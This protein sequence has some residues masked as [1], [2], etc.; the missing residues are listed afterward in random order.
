MRA[1]K[2][3]IAA[4]A[5]AS[6]PATGAPTAAASLAQNTQAPGFY[7]VALGDFTVTVLTDGST[8]VPFADLLHG[9]SPERVSSIFARA[10]GTPTRETSINAFL[11]DTGDRQVLID[12]GASSLF[13][14]C[15]GRLPATLSAAGYRAADID[16]ILLTHVH[17]DH[18]AGLVRD[19][20]R[21]FPNA[22][23]YLAEAELKF[24]A[25]DAARESAK[26]SHKRMFA[27]GQA[28]LAP[29]LEADR[30]RTFAGRTQLF[31][32]IASIPAPGHTPGHSFYRIESRGRSLLV[33]GDVIHSAEVQFE[34]P[35]VTVDFDIDEQ[36]A[37]ARRQSVLA[38]LART[39]EL[40]AAPHI[41][42]PGLGYI[43]RAK[44]GFAWAPLPY[45]ADVAEV[46]Q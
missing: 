18:S 46:G 43:Y 38:E 44:S 1:L 11:I 8:P 14:D 34:N 4:V 37:A 15:C 27:E 22:D 35:S 6:S 32:G 31:P 23:V 20:R 17:G 16:A 36:A 3:I 29:Y 7:R 21:V 40:V 24:W 33:I 10:G 25:S 41:S 2:L 45:S 42:F 12:A 5:L 28:A 39:R 13:G 19:G 9:I 30:I 26:P